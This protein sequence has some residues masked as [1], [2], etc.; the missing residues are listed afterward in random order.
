MIK[1]N[2]ILLLG[3]IAYTSVFSQQIKPFIVNTTGTT[4][5]SA[6]GQI[7]GNLGEVAIIKISN[8]N[9]GITQGFLQSEFISN[10]IEALKI[11]QSGLFYPNPTNDLIYFNQN[12]K[13]EKLNTSITDAFGR[14]VYEGAL[15]SNGISLKSL[16]VGLYQVIVINS[17]K[18]IIHKTTISKIN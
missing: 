12:G 15:T 13:I 5:I 17:N 10:G 18:K 1:Q 2:K 6:A 4:L 8:P 7:T 14:K 16:P 11:D 9:N 3:M